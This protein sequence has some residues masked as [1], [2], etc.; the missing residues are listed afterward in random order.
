ML[1]FFD[2]KE[3]DKFL[4]KNGTLVIGFESYGEFGTDEYDFSLYACY[5]DGSEWV[6]DSAEWEPVD[7][8]QLAKIYGPNGEIDSRMP[9]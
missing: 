5:W 3:A 6:L 8:Q 1:D 4:V 7:P 2:V 9:V